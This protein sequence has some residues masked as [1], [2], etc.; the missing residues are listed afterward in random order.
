[1]PGPE[2][3]PPHATSAEPGSAAG[4]R[5]VVVG[6][7]RGEG[8]ARGDGARIA[9]VVAAQHRDRPTRYTVDTWTLELRRRA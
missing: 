4:W 1:M 8:E 2:N 6:H 7:H 5:A 3:P 9:A